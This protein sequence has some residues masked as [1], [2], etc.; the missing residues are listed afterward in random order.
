MLSGQLGYGERVT[1]W[2]H[3]DQLITGLGLAGRYVK[4]VMAG[5]I[6]IGHIVKYNG[7]EYLAHTVRPIVKRSRP[8][9]C[10]DIRQ[11]YTLPQ[12][13]SIQKPETFK[14]STYRML[15]EYQASLIPGKK[16]RKPARKF[17]AVSDING[18]CFIGT[19]DALATIVN[20]WQKS[21]KLL[22]YN[23]ITRRQMGNHTYR[24]LRD[25][26]LVSLR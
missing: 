5:N 8:S 17:Y 26:N 21:G 25:K 24:L 22:S 14:Q 4:P 11:T 9:K 19:A 2:S 1:F 23:R 3:W 7:V 6:T 18:V 20:H 16:A 13:G 15:A 10:S 12:A